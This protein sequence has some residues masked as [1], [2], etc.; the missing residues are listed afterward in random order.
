MLQNGNHVILTVDKMCNK[1]IIKMEEEM[2]LI[3]PL[4]AYENNIDQVLDPNW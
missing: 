3:G 4:I 2:I 1:A